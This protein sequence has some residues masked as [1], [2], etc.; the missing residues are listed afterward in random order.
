MFT[1]SLTV[2]AAMMSWP[3]G[4][5]STDP[6]RRT[7]SAM[8]VEM[9]AMDAPTTKA[10]VCGAPQASATAKPRPRGSAEPTAPTARPR[11]PKISSSS[12]S[13]MRP[14]SKAWNTRPTSPMT[15]STAALG[16]KSRRWGPRMTP[17]TISPTS[18]GL[19]SACD[20]ARVDRVPPWISHSPNPPSARA[21]DAAARRRRLARD[22]DDAD[23]DDR[24]ND[25]IEMVKLA[26]VVA[27]VVVVVV[28]R[29]VRLVDG[30]GAGR[31]Q[32]EHREVVRGHG[33]RANTL[34]SYLMPQWKSSTS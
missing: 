6:T 21:C 10:L 1:T 19:P 18:D 34:G 14:T 32:D 16:T 2:A 29:C 8:P 13:T 20:G 11:A 22:P 12:T 4:W 17:A 23:E 33:P 26:A 7:F 5:F 3:M 25:H 27:A 31:R 28:V 9:D 30:G 15:F 24:E